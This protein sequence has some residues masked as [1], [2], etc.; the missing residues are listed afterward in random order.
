MLYS[1]ITT[2]IKVT[3]TTS[4]PTRLS[5]LE[6]DLTQINRFKCFLAE[7][8]V[9]IGRMPAGSWKFAVT[10]GSIMTN[11]TINVLFNRKIVIFLFPAITGMTAGAPAPVRLGRYSETIGN[12][13]LAQ[14]FFL[15]FSTS[16]GPMHRTMHLPGGQ[17][18]TFQT[19][20]GHLRP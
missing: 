5:D 11:Q 14:T 13:S 10:S 12:M 16:P 20:L 18:M 17:I 3:T 9:D 4:C 7:L 19:G 2:T 6:R 8:L 1:I 15:I